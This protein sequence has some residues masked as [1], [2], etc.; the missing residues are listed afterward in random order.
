MI[1]RLHTEENGT[2]LNIYNPYFQDQH[3]NAIY[4]L[5]KNPSSEPLVEG[6]RKL[7]IAGAITAGFEQDPKLPGLLDDCSDAV[8]VSGRV[9]ML[10][11]RNGKLWGHYQGGEGLMRAIQEKITTARAR[12][13]V[14]GA[15]TV[16]RTLV[17]ALTKSDQR[18]KEIVVVNRTVKKAEDLKNIS[19]LV[20]VIYDLDRLNKTQGDILVNAT[21]IGSKAEDSV[22]H[23]ELIAKFTAVADVTFGVES[24][25]LTELGRTKNKIVVSGW[26]MFTHQAAVVL[27]EVLGH[28]ANIQRLR[29]FVRLG[30]SGNNHGA[31]VAKRRLK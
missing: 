13:V 14:V 19:P 11:N 5:F 4:L 22:F 23:N 15:G 29:Y 25:N 3:L 8:R 1:A 17:L 20:T 9:G 2:G 28:E 26:D 31:T 21:R 24:T 27:R 30:L 18:P 6:L 7:Q 16:A 12:I 10:A